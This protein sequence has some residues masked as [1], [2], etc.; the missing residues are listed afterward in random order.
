MPPERKERSHETSSLHSHRSVQT[1]LGRNSTNKPSALQLIP[2]SGF[3]PSDPVVLPVGDYNELFLLYSFVL[4]FV[5]NL[6]SLVLG[7]P[8]MA[9]QP[10]PGV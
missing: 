2:G 5:F 10:K 4:G 6:I 8:P 9:F 7:F 1:Y 3:C